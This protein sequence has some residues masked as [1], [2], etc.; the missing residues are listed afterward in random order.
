MAQPSSRDLIYLRHIL[1]LAREAH[2]VLGVQ[3][4][5][6]YDRDRNLRLALAH[7]I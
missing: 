6:A 5:D 1:D 2:G 7:L 4:R 3:G